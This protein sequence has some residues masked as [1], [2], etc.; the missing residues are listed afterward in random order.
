MAPLSI[1]LRQQTETGRRESSQVSLSF[2]SGVYDDVQQTREVK[3]ENV[4]P[5]ALRTALIV[6]LLKSFIGS[7]LT[8][9][10]HLTPP[11]PSPSLLECR[12][13]Q[14]PVI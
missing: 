11:Q 3:K 13:P 12:K 8:A 2:F 10:F 1:C 4:R 6:L 14:S 5:S 9:N 7:R